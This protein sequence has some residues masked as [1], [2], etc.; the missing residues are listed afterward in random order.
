MLNTPV[1][2][3]VGRQCDP[4]HGDTAQHDEHYTRLRLQ[5]QTLLVLQQ[6]RQV[7]LQTLPRFMLTALL[8]LLTLLL[9][10]T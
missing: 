3:Q 7:M 2:H 9:Q 5:Q 10:Q 8:L 1:L 6:T 4:G